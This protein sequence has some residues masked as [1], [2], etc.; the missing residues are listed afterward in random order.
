MS[1]W[2]FNI[3]EAPRGETVTKTSTVK[4]KEVSRKVFVPSPVI[5]ATKCGKVMGSEWLPQGER[6]HGLATDEQPVAWMLWPTHPTS[7]PTTRD[8]AA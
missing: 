6:W 4:D 1:A 3:A 8:G 7:S 2:N 5:L